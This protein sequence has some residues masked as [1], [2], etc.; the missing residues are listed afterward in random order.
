MVFGIGDGNGVGPGL[1]DADALG[2]ESER[3]ENTLWF[4]VNGNDIDDAEGLG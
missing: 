3:R 4:M 1:G 2:K